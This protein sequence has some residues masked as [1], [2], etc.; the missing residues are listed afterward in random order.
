MKDLEAGA[1]LQ[2]QNDAHD[3]SNPPKVRKDRWKATGC[4]YQREGERERERERER[5]A[6]AP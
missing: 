2:L 3:T 1:L 5:R 4:E 6:G